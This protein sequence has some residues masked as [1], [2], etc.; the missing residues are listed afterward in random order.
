MY[1]F[2]SS[3]LGSHG[4]EEEQIQYPMRISSLNNIK[5]VSIGLYHSFCL[6]YDGNVYTFGD[7]K[8]GQLGISTEAI[9]STLIPH[10]VNL[11]SCKQIS[12][13]DNFTICLSEDG[14]LFSFGIN[15]YGPLGIG[16]YNRACASPEQIE[17]LLDVELVECG[18]KHSF[19]KTKYNEIYC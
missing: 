13:G 15:E 2:G 18:S 12:C 4:H 17:S 16:M 1:S 8:F 3:K 10:K 19:C 5:S 7:N 6:D 11:P 14:N 9:G